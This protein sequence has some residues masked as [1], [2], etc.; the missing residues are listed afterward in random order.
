[1]LFDEDVGFEWGV[2]FV[3]GEREIVCVG[4][5]EVDLVVWDELRAVD[6]DLGVVLVCDF[7]DL[8]DWGDFVGDV[9]CVGY[10]DEGC[11]MFCE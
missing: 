6:D 9:V 11:W 4:C 2:D 5:G 8:F 3:F 10:C 7:D 1:M